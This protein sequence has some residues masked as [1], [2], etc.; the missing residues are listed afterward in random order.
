MVFQNHNH[1]Y[2]LKGQVLNLIHQKIQLIHRG[3][4][5]LVVIIGTEISGSV[6]LPDDPD[7]DSVESPSCENLTSMK[8]IDI[9]ATPLDF[10][11]WVEKIIL[12][13]D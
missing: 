2:L 8:I 9:S 13:K 3:Y 7:S 11:F 5:V 1:I 4:L 10:I 6:G 12:H